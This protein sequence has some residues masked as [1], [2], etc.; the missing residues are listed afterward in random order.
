MFKWPADNQLFVPVSN[1]VRSCYLLADKNR[2]FEVAK[3]EKGITVQ[4]TGNA[5]DPICSVV[6]LK[7]AGPTTITAANQITQN[8]EGVI[9]LAAQQATIN[10]GFGTKVEVKSE[11]DAIGGWT[12]SGVSVEWVFNVDKPGNF[13]V[14]AETASNKESAF[15]VSMGEQSHKTKIPSHGKDTDFAAV[16]IGTFVVKKAGE[17]KITFQ[18]VKEAWNPVNLR[19]VT[20]TP[21]AH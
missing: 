11:T 20:M 8:K 18:P 14:T 6:V 12:T 16:E 3:S 5:P 10:N 1:P 15:V 4:L 19:S 7:L 13:T 2:T 17:Q 9:F 21:A